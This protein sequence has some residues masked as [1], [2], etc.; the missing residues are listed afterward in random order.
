MDKINQFYKDLELEFIPQFQLGAVVLIGLL[1]TIFITRFIF[2]KK[3]NLHSAVSSA[4]ATLFIYL[5]YAGL[6]YMPMPYLA[7]YTAM[8][9][10]SVAGHDLQ[11]FIFH[12][13]HYTLLCTHLLRMVILSLLVN[14]LDQIMP[15][16]NNFF[17]W[18]L[19]RVLT[20]AISLLLYIVAH[21]LLTRYLPE[22]I[23][24]YAPTV[25]I[26]LLILLF[27]TGSLK[28]LVGIALTTV[29]P[30]IAALYTFFFASV[31]GKMLSRA[32]LTTAILTVMSLILHSLDITVIYMSG[33]AILTYLPFFLLL[34]FIWYAI[35]Q[36]KKSTN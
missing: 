16:Q 17:L 10:V 32:M 9:L 20:V 12:G 7:I 30:L 8:P 35:R 27:L 5:G 33:N 1:L 14:I 31:V 25:L 4:I 26:I 6:T 21:T 11:L 19:I 23:T 34:I 13:A 28:L 24:V 15:K 29:S 22:A 2:G 3:D 18:L 36:R